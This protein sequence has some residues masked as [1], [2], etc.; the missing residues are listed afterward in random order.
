MNR[1]EFLATGAL[2]AAGWARSKPVRACVYGHTGRGGYGH[3][4]DTCFN[5]MD[6]VKVVGVADPDDKG[7]AAAAKRLELSKS[8]AAFAEMLDQERPDIASPRPRWVGERLG[9]PT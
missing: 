2:F 3:G 7:R 8:Y 6:N 1:R 5:W 9:L 4:L